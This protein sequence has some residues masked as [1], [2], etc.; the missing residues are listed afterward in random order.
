MLLC[1]KRLLILGWGSVRWQE[2]NVK[3]GRWEM[4][5]GLL[6]AIPPTT[7]RWLSDELLP[8][9]RNN[10]LENDT[11][12]VTFG[13][14]FTLDQKMSG[15]GLSAPEVMT[16]PVMYTPVV[17]ISLHPA[18]FPLKKDLTSWSF[19]FYQLNFLHTKEWKS[20]SFL[21]GGNV[22]GWTHQLS[23]GQVEVDVSI[24]AIPGRRRYVNIW[25]FDNPISHTRDW[26]IS[27]LSG[28]LEAADS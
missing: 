1:R 15:V 24:S 13:K 22:P 20:R 26:R 18:R 6:P 28:C 27:D 8:L 19:T 7:Q 17:H 14:A 12:F 3:R 16:T 4:S 5:R 10:I 9:C 11:G 23:I 21:P 25:M 2:Q